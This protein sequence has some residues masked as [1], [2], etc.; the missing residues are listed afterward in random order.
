MFSS[1]AF[2]I[3]SIPF[4]EADRIY[5][6]FS[7]EFGKISAR[8]RGVRKTTSKLGPHLLP[9]LP[10]TI[11]VVAGKEWYTI[12]GAQAHENKL[13]EFGE[14]FF[15]FYQYCT[16]LL[17]KAL[18]SEQEN[19]ELFDSLSL[20]FSH[21]SKKK[22]DILLLKSLFLMRFLEHTGHTI[23]LDVCLRCE[24]KKTEYQIDIEAGGFICKACSYEG[25]AVSETFRKSLK[26]LQDPTLQYVE[27]LEQLSLEG[28]EFLL[29]ILE[30][31][32]KQRFPQ[33]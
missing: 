18:P 3:H 24:Q 6:L 33:W 28:K 20:F 7:R 15:D 9:L 30:K 23:E 29:S 31:F 22:C 19:S 8:G 5:T 17:L 12:T 26:I 14:I 27:R 10:C 4:K 1:Q 2:V 16:P 13:P 11:E 21:M 25:I 32:T